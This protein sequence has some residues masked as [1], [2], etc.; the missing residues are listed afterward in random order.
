MDTL[1]GRSIH[2]FVC[3]GGNAIQAWALSILQFV[4]GSINFV[5]GDGGVNVVKGRVLGDV[6]KNGGVHWAVVVENSLKMRAKHCHILFSIGCRFSI[7][8]FHC[9]FHF[10]LMVSS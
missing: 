9:H 5:E 6:S 8:H 3:L 7:C 2:R 10:F 1:L 4:D